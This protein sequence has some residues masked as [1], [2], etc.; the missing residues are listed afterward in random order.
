[1]KPRKRMYT[2]YGRRRCKYLTPY[3]VCYS[4]GTHHWIHEV[5]A[6]SLKQAYALVLSEQ[7]AEGPSDLGIV[8]VSNWRVEHGYEAA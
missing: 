5:R 2:L 3:S 8:S 4:R 7:M 6:T 1:M